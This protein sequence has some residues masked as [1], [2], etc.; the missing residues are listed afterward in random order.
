M[1]DHIPNILVANLDTRAALQRGT[2]TTI[3]LPLS[4]ALSQPHT[5]PRLPRRMLFTLSR[6]CALQLAKGRGEAAVTLPVDAAAPEALDCV[7]DW[8]LSTCL[9]PDATPVRATGSFG[10]R[11]AVY[12]AALALGIRRE[13]VTEL[14]MGLLEFAEDGPALGMLEVKM[15]V[16]RL[17]GNGNVARALVKRI[18]GQRRDGEM[19]HG[20]LGEP[21]E[22][23]EALDAQRSMTGGVSASV[24]E[25][26]RS[27]AGTFRAPSPSPTPWPFASGWDSGL[28]EQ[29]RGRLDQHR[30]LARLIWSGPG[31][32]QQR[33]EVGAVS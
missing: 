20:E 11:V 31:T 23:G 27:T 8:M 26:E 13:A 15:A 21:P 12:Q 33:V 4:N 5:V 25:L 30:R 6:T 18:A 2:V 17:P 7:V 22:R 14:E 10:S 3:H 19:R 32:K 16:E 24:K 1:A 29:F 9:L 28:V